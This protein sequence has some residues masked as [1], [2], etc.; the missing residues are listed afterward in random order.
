[1]SETAGELPRRSLLR[2]LAFVLLGAFL[3]YLA[4]PAFE[5]VGEVLYSTPERFTLPLNAKYD[6]LRQLGE[7]KYVFVRYETRRRHP[8]SA[9]SG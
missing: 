4:Q 1:M 9:L 8:E 7:F 6:T 5:R 3:T 2:D